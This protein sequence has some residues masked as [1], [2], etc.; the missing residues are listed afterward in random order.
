MKGELIEVVHA[1][2]GRI[3]LKIKQLKHDPALPEQIHAHVSRIEWIERVEA[4]PVTGSVLVVFDQDGL[5]S[6]D[7][8]VT[9]SRTLAALFPGLHMDMAHVQQLLTAAE[10]TKSDAASASSVS[11]NGSFLN[12]YG[13]DS[14]QI[15]LN[16][17]LPLGLFALGLKDL[18]T[19][20]HMPF[21]SWY[22]LFWFAF[23]TYY[24]LNRPA[25]PRSSG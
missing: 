12:G 5:S 21:P 14:A 19:S 3:R 13:I 17:L 20:K 1:L 7:S 6:F 25:H 8:L 9:L 23:S 24:I 11:S 4:N 2:P 15:D 16:S 22:E 10:R 18:L